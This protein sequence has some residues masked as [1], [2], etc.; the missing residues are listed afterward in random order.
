MA[1]RKVWLN[2]RGKNAKENYSSNNKNLFFQRDG[3]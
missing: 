1:E 3:D 2:E